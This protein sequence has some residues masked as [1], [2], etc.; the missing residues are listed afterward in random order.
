MESIIQLILIVYITMQTTIIT[1]YYI[2]FSLN[3]NILLTNAY[4]FLI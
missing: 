1:S 2:L 3:K 4:L